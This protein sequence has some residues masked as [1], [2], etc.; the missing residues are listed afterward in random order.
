MIES[1]INQQIGAKIRFYRK[2]TKMSIDELAQAIGKSR[3]TVSKYETGVI[4]IDVSTLVEIAAV[5]KINASYLIN[6]P[7]EKKIVAKTKNPLGGADHFYL[8]Q[9]IHRKNHCS[10][11]RF[12][13]EE[14]D[15]RIGVTFYYK[16]DNIR[17]FTQCEGIYCGHMNT[18]DNIVI[19]LLN[20]LYS[21]AEIIYLSFLIPLKKITTVPGIM[22]GIDTYSM[23]PTSIEVVLSKDL[24][25]SMEIGELFVASKEQIKKVKEDHCFVVGI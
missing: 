2:M 18:K 23:R 4:A 15:G 22:T 20:N 24:L 7:V 11:I 25:S 14:E 8:Y 10:Y 21:E 19:F 13:N 12:E 5:L 9:R 16:L 17:D 1:S 3:A 6:M